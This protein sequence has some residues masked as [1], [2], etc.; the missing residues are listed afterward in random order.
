MSIGFS[1]KTGTVDLTPHKK[2]LDGDSPVN[3]KKL[4]KKF[5]D[6]VTGRQVG[7]MVP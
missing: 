6:F 3:K 7:A 5:K 4:K 1:D 2:G